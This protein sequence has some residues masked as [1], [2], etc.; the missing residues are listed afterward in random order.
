MPETSKRARNRVTWK[1]AD[2]RIDPLRLNISRP[3]R[4]RH[5]RSG[6]LPPRWGPYKEKGQRTPPTAHGRHL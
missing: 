3:V 6:H 2:R 5:P 4:V 1:K